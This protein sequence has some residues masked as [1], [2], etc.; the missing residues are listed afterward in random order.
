M[1][2]EFFREHQAINEREMGIYDAFQMCRISE[3]KKSKGPS[4]WAGEPILKSLL[5]FSRFSETF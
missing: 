2:I 5:N 1:K 4:H 3:A